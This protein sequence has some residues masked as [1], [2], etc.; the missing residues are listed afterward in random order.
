MRE[1]GP[2]KTRKMLATLLGDGV[3]RSDAERALLETAGECGIHLSDSEAVGVVKANPR[4]AGI[5]TGELDQQLTLSA[6][7]YVEEE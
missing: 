6:R 2:E 4:V 1:K 3:L 5:S 7:R